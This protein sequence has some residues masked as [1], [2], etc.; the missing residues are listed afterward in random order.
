[1]RTISNRKLSYLLV[2]SALGLLPGLSLACQDTPV[3][4]STESSSASLTAAAG[5]TSVG[6][7]ATGA[8][9]NSVLALD[10]GGGKPWVVQRLDRLFRRFDKDGDGKI[11]LKDLP[12]RLRERLTR[13][14]TNN[15]GFVTRDEIMKA[16]QSTAAEL[17]AKID[18]NGDGVI[19]G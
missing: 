7:P 11:A 17:K 8:G 13:A 14:D 15:D 10:A 3:D 16:W 4:G 1:M 12:D 5:S 6:A 18:T 19:S 9:S 2:Y